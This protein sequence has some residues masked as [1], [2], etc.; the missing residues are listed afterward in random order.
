MNGALHDYGTTC[1]SLFLQG[2]SW[3]HAAVGITTIASRRTATLQ[4]LPLRGRGLP[5]LPHSSFQ[6]FIACGGGGGAE[7]Q[8]S[9]VVQGDMIGWCFH[10]DLLSKLALS[11]WYSDVFTCTNCTSGRIWVMFSLRYVIG[12]CFKFLVVKM[13]FF[14]CITTLRNN[15]SECG[16][17]FQSSLEGLSPM[18]CERTLSLPVVLCPWRFAYRN[19][20][21]LCNWRFA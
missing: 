11:F 19:C 16:M 7:A 1:W 12:T 14:I 10:F 9:N 2:R 17:F 15:K 5:A 4:W 13:M 3:Y 20:K 8:S 21:K 6:I 18:D